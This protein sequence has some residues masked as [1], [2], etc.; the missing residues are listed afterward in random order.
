MNRKK[1]TTMK[2][3]LLPHAFQKAGWW[4]LLAS[5]VA[6]AAALVLDIPSGA[7]PDGTV[8]AEAAKAQPLTRVILA[9]VYLSF[10]LIACSRE[11]VE[12]E[13]VSSMRLRAIASVACV[14]FTIYTA[15]A[16]VSTITGGV[17][18]KDLASSIA[19]PPIAF[20]AYE[21]VLRISIAR[22]RKRTSL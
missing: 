9:A 17:M 20:W 5:L 8:T 12:D 14:L 16:V 3:F 11:K 10:L 19:S 18:V 6:G 7:L 15:I 4:L 2:R 13:M 1:Q 22:N 21:I